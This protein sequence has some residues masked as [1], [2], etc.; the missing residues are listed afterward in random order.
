MSEA[1]TVRIQKIKKNTIKG[2]LI[3]SL[4]LVAILLL[5]T[6]FADKIVPYDPYVQDLNQ[7]R[8]APSAAHWMGTDQYGRDVFSR[9][10]V[11]A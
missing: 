8:Q 5:I 1:V 4:V 9:V 7:S 3:F 11:G 2:R 10:V 6:V